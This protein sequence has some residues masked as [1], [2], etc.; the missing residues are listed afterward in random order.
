TA[1]SAGPANESGQSLSFTV[2]TTNGALF[3][4]PPAIAPNG[5]L[6]YTPAAAGSGSATVTVV[7]TDGGGTANGGIDTSAAQTFTITVNPASGSLTVSSLQGPVAGAATDSASAG[8]TTFT[9]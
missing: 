7:L 4:T 8:F 3:A 9:G 2:T 1:I 5:T 6:T